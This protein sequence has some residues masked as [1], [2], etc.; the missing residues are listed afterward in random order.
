MNGRRECLIDN[1]SNLIKFLVAI[2][3]CQSVLKIERLK[4]GRSMILRA[5][6]YNK[7]MSRKSTERTEQFIYFLLKVLFSRTYFKF[8]P[9][10]KNM[11]FSYLPIGDT[12]RALSEMVQSCRSTRNDPRRFSLRRL[13]RRRPRFLPGQLLF[14]AHPETYV[15]L[16]S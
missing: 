16:S 3:K 14:K 11:M 6:Y 10:P 9:R 8:F 1:F 2:F 12:E 4:S 15:T 13:Q 5:F 7:R